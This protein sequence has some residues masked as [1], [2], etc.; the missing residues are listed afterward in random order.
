VGARLYRYWAP[1]DDAFICANYQIM[2]YD[3]I[4]ERLAR[5][6]ASVAHRASHVLRLRKRKPCKPSAAPKAKPKRRMKL[7]PF[8]YDQTPCA[9]RELGWKR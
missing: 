3:E 4:A 8:T 9:E 1:A 2:T 7:K 6:S 5:N